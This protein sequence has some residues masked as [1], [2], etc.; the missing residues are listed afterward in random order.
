MKWLKEVKNSNNKPWVHIISNMKGTL[1]RTY[2]QRPPYRY[3]A[4]GRTVVDTKTFDSSN[5]DYPKIS[6]L[7]YMY[8]LY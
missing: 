2:E 8:R 7:S 5:S 1:I 6:G 4:T 3:N